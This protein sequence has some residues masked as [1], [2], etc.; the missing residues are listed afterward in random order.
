MTTLKPAG[1]PEI[2]WDSSFANMM[3]NL[4][5]TRDVPP[6]HPG[7]NLTYV[8]DEEVKELIDKKTSRN[9]MA[10]NKYQVCAGLFDISKEDQREQYEAIM[11]N[12]YQKGWLAPVEERNWSQDGATM[13]IFLKYFIPI[14]KK[15][16][17]DSKPSP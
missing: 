6:A 10:F 14:D 3:N 17:D 4:G 8:S 2:P 15:G 9:L 11:N 12:V 5:T 16:S 7:D 1:G 13:I